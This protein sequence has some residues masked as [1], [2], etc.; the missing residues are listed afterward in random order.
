MCL[1]VPARIVRLHGLHA[2]ADLHG[3]RVPIN[4]TLV[5][6]AGE[7]D[8]V[9]LHAG[10]AISKL[11]S[12]EATETWSILKDLA[13]ADAAATPPTASPAAR[14]SAAAPASDG[15]AR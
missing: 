12:K 6:D 9:L 3:N 2:E 5:P 7:G 13:A 4:T 8:W 11:D 15:G 1:A 10:F 14:R